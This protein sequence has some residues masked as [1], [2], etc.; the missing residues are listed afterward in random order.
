VIEVY[1]TCPVAQRVPVVAQS[2]TKSPFNIDIFY[3][4]MSKSSTTIKG[5]LAFY[6]IVHNLEHI[7]LLY[8]MKLFLTDKNIYISLIVLV[9]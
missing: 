7:H 8:R 5:K 6:A 9:P 2:G 3:C 1:A 4:Y